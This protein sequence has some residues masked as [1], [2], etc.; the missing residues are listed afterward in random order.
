MGL[1]LRDWWGRLVGAAACLGLLAWPIP[2]TAQY[3]EGLSHVYPFYYP[4]DGTGTSNYGLPN[5]PNT[6]SPVTGPIGI[7]PGGGFP[8]PRTC[9]TDRG[10]VQV[11]AWYRIPYDYES[12]RNGQTQVTTY[13]YEDGRTYSVEVNQQ[14]ASQAENLF[15]QLNSYLANYDQ[16]VTAWGYRTFCRQV[17]LRIINGW[18][19]SNL[20]LHGIFEKRSSNAVPTARPGRSN[21]EQGFAV[22]ISYIIPEGKRGHIISDRTSLAF[23]WLATNTGDGQLGFKNLPSEPWHWSRNGR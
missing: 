8:A 17:G 20:D 16:A 3:E 7:T 13:T 5:Y 11:P 19:S 6:P 10:R 15:R 23:R 14:I 12:I 2:A 21:H 4:E 22:D 18:A 1:G 9:E